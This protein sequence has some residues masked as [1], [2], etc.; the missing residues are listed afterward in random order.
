M[1]TSEAA[2]CGPRFLQNTLPFRRPLLSNGDNHTLSSPLRCN[3]FSD[4]LDMVHIKGQERNSPDDE[5]GQGTP[6]LG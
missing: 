2:V 1:S 3:T 4:I 5:V 6:N